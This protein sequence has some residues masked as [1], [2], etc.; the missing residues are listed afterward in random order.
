[1]STFYAYLAAM[2][3]IV[4]LMTMWVMVQLAWRKHFPKDAGDQDA[5][6]GRSGCY[7]CALDECCESRNV[8]NGSE[9][10]GMRP[11]QVPHRS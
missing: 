5:L 6:A 2:G 8:D 3:V 9:S 4:G 7:G 11:E 10:H 1:L